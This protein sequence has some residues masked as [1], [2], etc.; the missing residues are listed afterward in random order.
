[1]DLNA[2]KPGFVP[3]PY[4][5]RNGERPLYAEVDGEL[6]LVGMTFTNVSTKVSQEES[7]ATAHLFKAS[8]DLFDVTL[9]AA[10]LA[11]LAY[12]LNEHELRERI[13]ALLDPAEVALARAT[14]LL[15]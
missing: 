7:E 1:M 11:D 9:A 12:R 15:G 14:G 6:V 4:T 2:V 5:K 10:R 8:T 13:A 3:G